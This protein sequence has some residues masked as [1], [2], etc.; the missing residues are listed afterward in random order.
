[1]SNHHRAHESKPRQYGPRSRYTRAQI[2]EIREC[3][4]EWTRI[5]R[6]RQR[7]IADLAIDPRHWHR[8]GIGEVGNNPKL[9]DA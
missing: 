7:L 3:F 5:K 8:I 9:E 2:E 1:M 6:W 4:A